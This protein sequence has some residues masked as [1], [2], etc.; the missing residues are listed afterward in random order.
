MKKE[1]ILLGLAALAAWY[2]LFYKKSDDAAASPSSDAQVS[3]DAAAQED[4]T[5]LRQVKVAVPYKVMG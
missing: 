5:S 3:A 1:Y 2:F 4:P